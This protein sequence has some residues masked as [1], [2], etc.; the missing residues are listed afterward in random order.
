M[1]VQYYGSLDYFRQELGENLAR[2]RKELG[3]TQA[4][5]AEKLGVS[6]SSV[7][8]VE[9][10]EC[11]LSLFMLETYLNGLDMKWGLVATPK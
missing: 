10:G 4:Q 3:L 1:L 5:L 7:S 11:A 9:R 2:R 6:Q 8:Q